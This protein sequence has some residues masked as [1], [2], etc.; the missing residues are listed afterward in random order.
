MDLTTREAVERGHVPLRIWAGRVVSSTVA[1]GQ[2][3]AVRYTVALAPLY[4]VGTQIQVFE[5]VT[6]VRM[7]PTDQVIRAAVPDKSM[8][9][10]LQASSD[11]VRVFIDGEELVLEDCP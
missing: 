9:W 6:P 4:P 3:S 1:Q 5:N 11:P 2:A 10:A 7:V 8:V